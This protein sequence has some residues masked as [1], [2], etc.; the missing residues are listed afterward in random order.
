MKRTL[1]PFVAGFCLLQAAFS[2]EIVSRSQGGAEANGKSDDGVKISRN[3]RY[4][5]FYSEATN[6]VPNDTNGRGDLFVADRVSG[7]VVRVSVSSG[8]AE[9]AGSI[10]GF[11]ISGDGRFVAFVCSDDSLVA[12][13]SNGQ[14]DVLLRDLGAGTTELISVHSNG[15]QGNSSSDNPSLSYDGQYVAFESFSSNLIA[16][17]SNSASDIFVRDRV[18]STT[19]RVSLSNSGLPANGASTQPSISDDGTRISFTSTAN[20]IVPN[21]TNGSRDVFV[22]DRIAG[23]T[24]AASVDSMGNLDTVGGAI[25]SLA[26][27][28]SGNGNV[29]AFLSEIESLAPGD[30][31]GQMDVI[32]RD[33]SA[34]TTE[35]AS[36]STNGDQNTSE[37]VNLSSIS[38]DGRFVGF[39]TSTSLDASDTY[40]STDVFI[41]DRTASTTTVFSLTSEGAAS[42]NPSETIAISG[43]GTVAAFLSGASNLVT[44][45]FNGV[46]DV[47]ARLTA[48]GEQKE[49]AQ[50]AARAA[51]RASL[52]RKIKKLQKKAKT[53]KRKGRRTA[54]KRFL[55]KVKKLKVQLRGL[56]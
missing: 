21:D 6:L 20:N 25:G 39:D 29:V 51:K 54:A 24:V 33:L 7:S 56:R 30:S 31:N 55:K 9:H 35:L 38:D 3:G 40:F 5:L 36:V 16:S 41:R 48:F 17:D 26:S 37:F 50:A 52:S 14:R 27:V 23:T 8:G 22:R 42:N 4:V 12:S 19:A 44:P 43:D 46:A 45:D 32:V 28:L 15:T 18:S 13:D 49:A 1:L 47:F 53:L 34:G 11:D 10:F 2:L